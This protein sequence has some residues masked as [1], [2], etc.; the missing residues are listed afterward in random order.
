VS[1]WKLILGWIA[2]VLLGAS[3]GFSMGWAAW[4]LGFELLGGAI[5]LAG[6]GVGGIVMFFIFLSWSVD[7]RS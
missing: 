1:G 7:Q 5:A 2:C 3:A 6:A 4:R